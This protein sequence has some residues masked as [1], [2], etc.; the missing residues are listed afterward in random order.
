MK[1][2]SILLVLLVLAASVAVAQDAGAGAAAA[3]PAAKAP[4]GDG[5]LTLGRGYLKVSAESE[6]LWK[7]LGEAQADL[8]AKEWEIFTLLNAEK[9]DKQAVAAKMSEGRDLMKQTR[10][11]RDK[12]KAYWVPLTAK[13][14]G[15][16]KGAH[17]KAQ[18]VA[19][20]QPAPAATPAPAAAPAQ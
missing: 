2:A 5:V 6:A 20:A 13:A 3:A 14:G 7:Q 1:L 9:V 4:K 17:H 15:K 19:P 11:L 8:R 16:G 10:D 12:L 18:G